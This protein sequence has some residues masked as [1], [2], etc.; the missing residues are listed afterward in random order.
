[1]A[2]RTVYFPE[3]GHMWRFINE[4]H[5]KNFTYNYTFAYGYALTYDE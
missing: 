2:K 4:H 3:V 5:V 1:M